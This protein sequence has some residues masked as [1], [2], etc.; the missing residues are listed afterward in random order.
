MKDSV[1]LRRYRQRH[2]E[3]DLPGD[4]SGESRWQQVLVLPA[5]RESPT[6]LEVLQQLPRGG[7]RSLVILVLNRPDEDSDTRANEDLRAAIEAR[8]PGA[9]A[10]PPIMPLNKHTELFLLD[11][12][13]LRGPTPASQ[14]VGLARKAGCDLALEWMARG[15]IT[16]EWIC[17]TD[18]DAMLPDDY[19]NRLDGTN[20]DAVAAVFP[21][22]HIPDGEDA[23]DRATAL[24]EL[25]LHH[26]V[27]GLDHAGSPYA[28][29]SLGSC[30]AV[31]AEAYAQVRGFPKRA[32]AEDFYLLN[33]L[34]KLGPINRLTGSPIRIRSR[35]SSRVPFGTGPAVQ[36]I[37]TG[38]QSEAERIFYHP[39]CYVALRALL[40]GLDELAAKPGVDIVTLLSE[41]GLPM[42]VATSARDALAALGL[43]Q[44]L[45]HCRRQGKSPAS[46]ERHFHQW[47]DGFLTLKFVHALRDSGWP[48]QSLAQ[49]A[50][51]QPCLW[52]TPGQDIE[53]L[54]SA[55]ER[56]WNWR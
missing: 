55:V 27:L 21:F 43:Q 8:M 44:A 33:K 23:V 6:L 4:I 3:E 15:V 49:L 16:S 18:A 14:G 9:Q 13:Q 29:H 1:A 48:M 20:D 30:L 41:R 26:H 47:F 42:S 25:R 46:F 7:A 38:V 11:L 45:E 40:Q 5:Y 10:S 19:Y 51:L 24:Y 34:A 17:S 35:Q 22:R 32:G 37:A 56:H 39:L 28:F 53:Q 36:A 12:E 31:R 50:T 52:P 54:R 2:M